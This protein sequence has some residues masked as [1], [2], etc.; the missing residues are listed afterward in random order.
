V[1]ITATTAMSKNLMAKASMARPES[2][3]F[4]FG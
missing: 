2:V 3:A 1:K 4:A